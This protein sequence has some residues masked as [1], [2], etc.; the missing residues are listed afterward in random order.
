MEDP[1]GRLPVGVA[2]HHGKERNGPHEGRAGEGPGQLP[3]DQR[4]PCRGVPATGQ[5]CTG[6]ADFGSMAFLQ[7]QF[8]CPPMLGARRT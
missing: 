6:G 3:A 8:L 4:P 7:N 2:V 1:F 5:V